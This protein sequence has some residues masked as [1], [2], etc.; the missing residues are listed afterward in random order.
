MYS[1]KQLNEPY[2]LSYGYI[3]RAPGILN[4]HSELEFDKPNKN[5]KG[6][7]AY[8]TYYGG[9]DGIH[10]DHSLVTSEWLNSKSY[11]WFGENGF[12][13]INEKTPKNFGSR[14]HGFETDN[15]TYEFFNAS[16][17][18]SARIE[19]NNDGFL[20]ETY[21]V[22]EDGVLFGEGTLG[23]PLR[24]YRPIERVSFFSNNQA[25]V[26]QTGTGIYFP[27]SCNKFFGFDGDNLKEDVTKSVN[28][29]G[30]SSNLN[31]EQSNVE[32]KYIDNW[33]NGNGSWWRPTDLN[34]DSGVPTDKGTWSWIDTEWV[35]QGRNGEFPVD[36][37]QND[38]DNS[39]LHIN[40]QNRGGRDEGSFARLQLKENVP[41]LP[42]VTRILYELD[43][44]S[45]SN[46]V[47]NEEIIPGVLYGYLGSSPTRFWVERSLIRRGFDY[48]F[49]ISDMADNNNIW[50]FD[51]GLDTWKTWCETPNTHHNF[52]LSAINSRVSTEGLQGNVNKYQNIILDFNTTTSYD[53]I[54]WGH[55]LL[56]DSVDEDQQ[57]CM[58]NLKNI[59]VLQDCLI[60]DYF[61]KNFFSS[62]KGRVDENE[63]V[64]SKSQYILQDILKSELNYQKSIV[65]PDITIEDDWINSFSL[66][67]QKDAKSVINDLFNSSIY[68]PS[69]DSSGNFKFLEIKQEIDYTNNYN[70]KTDDVINY[71]FDLTKLEDVKNYV[72]V[73]YK[74][75][76]ST[77]DYDQQTTFDWT[78]PNSTNEYET[79]DYITQQL[80]PDQPYDINYYNLKDDDAK[81][82]VENDYIRDEWTAARLK[83]KLL[84][85]HC[86]Q[87]LTCKIDLPPSYMNLESGDYIQFDQ[88]IGNKLAFGYDY[89]QEFIKNGQLIYPVFFITKVTKSL[90]KVSVE[91]IQMHH[92]NKQILLH[93]NNL[94]TI[95]NPYNLPYTELDIASDTAY[96]NGSWKDN[97]NYMIQ[98]RTIEFN[99]ESNLEPLEYDVKIYQANINLIFGQDTSFTY[100][101][102]T[103]EEGA[104]T[105]DEAMFDG[106]DLSD[107]FDISIID[108]GTG[109]STIKIEKKIYFPVGLE[110]N[111]H[112][113]VE[114]NESDSYQGELIVIDNFYQRNDPGDYP[115][116]DANGDYALNILDIV[117]TI[118]MILGNADENFNVDMNDDGV[119]NI[120]DIIILIN[121]ILED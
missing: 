108:T 83:L 96:L 60:T 50:D 49:E 70:I 22:D 103:Y 3:D 58:A 94:I 28:V 101:G 21:D 17:T 32:D 85:W 15:K 45:P 87:H 118:N 74:K 33:T 115:L 62:I 78:T 25:T 10:N 79:I 5:I 54:N 40:A 14:D 46:Y 56:S 20:Y 59:Y 120:L 65:L 35:N 61:N 109:T 116:G 64:I 107:L 89:T 121:E 100:N 63:V 39:G 13:P 91:A 84:M 6:L 30:T 34:N 57:S 2:P 69:Y 23:I 93:K 97:N 104:Y 41:T 9:N 11:L 66:T 26:N 90:N 99:L 110:L 106:V 112:L 44:F 55:T 117:S 4:K 105:I 7:W 81:L 38:E 82:L 51:N 48:N 68:I 71:S 77:D 31:N 24:I 16:S 47:Y 73:K 8:E 80:N 67:K 19:F 98:G 114:H 72:S 12:L 119:I 113:V 75:N 88:L 53:S 36:L 111:C 37:I 95:D 42:A 29:F 92:L 76:Y 18:K 27:A 52:S 43:Y 102:I 86:N 1:E